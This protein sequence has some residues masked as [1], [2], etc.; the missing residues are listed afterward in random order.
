MAQTISITH[1][2]RMTAAEHSP[3]DLPPNCRITRALTV[4]TMNQGVHD[5]EYAVRG[6]VLVKA[7][8]VA[9]KLADP[10]QAAKLSFQRLIKCNIGNPHAVQQAPITFFRQVA[11]AIQYPPLVDMDPPVLPPDVCRRAREYIQ[12]MP[13]KSVGSYTE[14]DGLQLVRKQVASF[15]ERRDGFPADPKS[16]ELTTGASEAVKRCIQVIL[17]DDNDAVMVPCPQYPLY[18]CAITMFGGHVAYYYLDEDRG[19]AVDVTEL[20]ASYNKATSSGVKV[21]SIAVINP[22]NPCGSVL[23]MDTMADILMFAAEENLVLLADEVYQENIYDE[24]RPFHSFKKVL[25]LLQQKKEGTCDPIHSVQLISFHSTS[26]GVLGE[27]GQRGGYME[28][29]GFSTRMLAQFAKVA[30]SSLSSNTLGQ[31]FVGLMVCPPVEGEESYE[32]YR[33]EHSL[34]FEGLKRR[35]ARLCAALNDIPG[36][37]CQPIAGA[38]YAFPNI[39]IPTAAV[40]AAALQNMKADEY[41]C[42]DLVEKTGIVCVPGSGFGQKNGTWHLRMTILPPDDMMEDVISRFKR[43]HEDFCRKYAP[44]E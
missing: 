42:I 40:S 36:V 34:I 6:A 4:S 18:S 43:F 26:K 10:A 27:C 9:A 24:G 19:W 28:L 22:G 12:A 17:T 7:T 2:R 3:E 37:S 16:I 11:A 29:V 23:D 14:S 5:S 30:A 13:G 1:C 44:N 15:I 33:K 31:V 39:T 38:M 41:Y 20:R 21:R 8:E 32:L 25:R 35:A